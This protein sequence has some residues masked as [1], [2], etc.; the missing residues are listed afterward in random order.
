[1]NF[2]NTESLTL[3]TTSIKDYTKTPILQKNK[4]KKIEIIYGYEPLCGWCYG[5]SNEIT[6]VISD[7]KSIADFKLA[8]GG[9]FA[10]FRSLKMGYISQHIK[11]NM[12][13]VS[14]RSGRIFGEKFIKLLANDNYSYDSKKASIA[15]AIMREIYSEGAFEFASDIQTA[16]FQYGKD[17]QS[18]TTYIELLEDYPIDSDYF[19][20]RL[21]SKIEAEKIELEFLNT[22][23][24]G[25]EGY[26]ACAIKVNGHTEILN[27]GYLDA[28]QIISKILYKMEELNYSTPI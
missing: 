3:E 6:A 19:I 1:M 12:K 18:D 23:I 24:L 9:I 26:P 25:F 4:K 16:F 27:Q 5:F 8:N 7:L 10:G 17:I 22:Q 2:I 15:V 21:N 14:D 28:S 13:N 11:N 20:S